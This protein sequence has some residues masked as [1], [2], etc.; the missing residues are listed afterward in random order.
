MKNV[1]CWLTF[2]LFLLPDCA[3]SQQRTFTN[4]IK[5]SGPDPWVVQ[6]DDWY[7]YMNTTGRNLTL[8]KTRNMADLATAESKVIYTPPSG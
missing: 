6:K 3:L 5:S 7:Y 1:L 4:P 8:W 2:L